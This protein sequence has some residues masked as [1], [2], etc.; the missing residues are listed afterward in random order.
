MYQ[1]VSAI[2]KP[3]TGN[4][5]W[6]SL[7]ISAI[8]LMTLYNTYSEI[9]ATLSNS[10]LTNNV[11]LYLSAIR[12][13]AGGEEITFPQFL[14]NNGNLALPTVN[15]TPTLTTTYA[16][17]ADAFRAGYTMTPVDSLASIDSN[18]PTSDK[19]W[20]LMTKAGVDYNQ[21]YQY[22][23]VTVN[24]FYHRTDAGPS[25]GYVVDG[26]KSRQL[27]NRNGI[28]V[29]S[30]SQI[31]S[32]SFIPITPQ[33]I[34]K[35]DPTQ[36]LRDRCFINTGIDLSNKTVMLVLGGYLHIFDNKTFYPISPSCFAINFN[37]ISYLDRFYE[38]KDFIDMS[39]LGLEVN[40]KNKDQISLVELFSDSV[41]T[42]YCS[43]SQSFFVVIDNQDIFIEYEPLHASGLPGMYI[44][45]TPPSFPVTTQQ[46]KHPNYWDVL[47]GGQWAINID[48]SLWKNYVYYKSNLSNANGIS[49]VE[50][51]STIVKNPPAWFFKIGKDTIT[52]S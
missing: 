2:V 39:S 31:G 22:C 47:D 20:L 46:G 49:N 23:L 3:L 48:D 52:F 43:L 10:A 12:G 16:H 36:N 32:L 41:I 28:G 5:R 1:L 50:Q 35:Q 25:G 7:D 27:S 21:F 29:Y 13:Q 42:A 9:I 15:G 34:Y 38:S 26:N 14:T 37:S 18:I 44:G 30:F 6:V 33:M 51:S 4:K 24:G 11:S 45:Y 19:T 17:Y 40:P 8:S